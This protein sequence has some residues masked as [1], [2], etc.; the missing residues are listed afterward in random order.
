[1]FKRKE[2]A[3][4]R[5]GKVCVI[6]NEVA[7]HLNET[8]YY[9]NKSISR[10]ASNN[11]NYI[12]GSMFGKQYGYREL[13]FADCKLVYVLEDSHFKGLVNVIP[14]AIRNDTIYG[15]AI[16]RYIGVNRK[17]LFTTSL[18]SLSLSSEANTE[19]VLESAYVHI[20]KTDIIS[21]LNEIRNQSTH[22]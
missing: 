8:E 14:L 20:V 2:A 13:L 16:K 7:N 21:Y 4:P 5:V 11:G 15:A 6:K 17:K 1:M 10:F 12:K 3:P 9:K 18:D 22:I 19:S